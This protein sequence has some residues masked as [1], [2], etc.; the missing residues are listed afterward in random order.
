MWSGIIAAIPNGFVLCD[1]L[2]GTPDLRNR[3]VV[4]AGREAG[5]GNHM[6]SAGGIGIGYWGVGQYGG[7]ELHTLLVSEM[8]SHAHKFPG[9]G[10]AYGSGF[11]MV[12]GPSALDDYYPR[13][14]TDTTVAVGD[15]QPH[16]NL[17]PYFALCFIMK[18]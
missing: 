17:P 16:N 14:R 6:L 5:Q 12:S 13:S 1:G 11:G 15:N 9:N 10:F 18:L 8:P 4:G 7:E 3:F 2:N